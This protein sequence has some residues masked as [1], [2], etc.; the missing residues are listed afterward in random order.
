MTPSFLQMLF[1]TPMEIKGAG[2]LG[3]LLPLALSISLVYKTIRCE[4]LS[5]VPLASLQ[6]GVMIVACMLLIG[7][8]LLLSYHFLA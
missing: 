7:V 4:R 6:L 8:M 2:R 3:M 5:A 1:E